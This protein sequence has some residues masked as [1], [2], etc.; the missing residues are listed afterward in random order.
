MRMLVFYPVH[1]CDFGTIALEAKSEDL[2]ETVPMRS[3]V[4]SVSSKS[5]INEPRHEI[6]NNNVAWTFENYLDP[7]GRQN[8]HFKTV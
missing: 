8:G 6:S 1:D 4:R 7:N 3:F 2:D 5:K